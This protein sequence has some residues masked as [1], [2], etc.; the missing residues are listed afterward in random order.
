MDEHDGRLQLAIGTDVVE[1]DIS[2]YLRPTVGAGTFPTVDEIQAGLVA[3]AD[4]QPSS[5][6]EALYAGRGC[7][8]SP[9]IGNSPAGQPLRVLSV[10]SGEI[11]V[12]VV[13]G[14]HPNEPG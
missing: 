10:G 1:L 4:S 8:L 6:A 3:L 5:L 2:R 13:A 12:L 14:V 9:P 11:H 7:R